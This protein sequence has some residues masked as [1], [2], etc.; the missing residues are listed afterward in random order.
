LRVVDQFALPA[1]LLRGL[2]VLGQ[3]VEEQDAC[4]LKTRRRFKSAVNLLPGLAMPQKVARMFV[5]NERDCGIVRRPALAGEV[6]GPV[7]RT[8][9]AQQCGLNG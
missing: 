1:Q 5:P 9:I 2:D 4:T 8:R 6:P 7:A 3:I